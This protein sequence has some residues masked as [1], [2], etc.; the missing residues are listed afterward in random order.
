MRHPLGVYLL[1]MVAACAP[2]AGAD[3]AA[4]AVGARPCVP[5]ATAA[6]SLVHDSTT[7]TTRPEIRSMAPLSYPK[8][9]R[10]QGIQGRVVVQVWIAATGVVDST[11][12]DSASNVG[13]VAPSITMIR[14]STF[15]PACVGD[16]PVRYT[17]PLP[18]SFTLGYR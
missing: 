13:F 4:N 10:E 9:L 5:V 18:V 15:W 11:A 3:H 8:T 17:A 16:R 7:V 12:L 1:L 2:T 6:D 14:R